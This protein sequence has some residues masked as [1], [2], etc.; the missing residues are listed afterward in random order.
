LST[1]GP[2]VLDA[3]RESDTLTETA[4][5][6]GRGSMKKKKESRM[7]RE[8]FYRIDPPIMDGGDGDFF[9]GYWQLSDEEIEALRQEE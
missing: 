6:A 4:D 8:E 1:D 9:R 3:R 2:T 5:I 7:S